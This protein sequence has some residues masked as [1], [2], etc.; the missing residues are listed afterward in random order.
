MHLDELHSRYATSARQA[1]LVA[2]FSEATRLE[3]GFW[4]MGWRVGRRQSSS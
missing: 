2:I 4:E 1:E 3:A